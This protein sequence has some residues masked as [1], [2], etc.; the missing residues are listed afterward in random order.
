MKSEV[1]DTASAYFPDLKIKFKN[2]SLLIKLLSKLLFFNKN[3]LTSYTTTIGST[4]YYPSKEFYNKN[5]TKAFLILMHEL[6]HVYDAKK[7]NK[8]LF[9]FLYLTPQIFC[10]LFIPLFLLGLYVPAFLSLLFLL[11]L[12]SYFRKVAE[13][14]A[15]LCSLYTMQKLNDKRVSNFNLD[16]ES[17]FYQ[18]QFTN[19]SYYFMWWFSLQNSF[20]EGL[21]LIKTGDHPYDDEI[22]NI[23]DKIIAI[24]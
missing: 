3:F 15:Y 20:Q 13:Q 21:A 5:Q 24:Y 23:I 6:V 10:L 4:I 11:P 22:F 9:S 12:P 7:I 17:S 19:S 16:I 18:K 1:I 8:F 14:R 2:Q